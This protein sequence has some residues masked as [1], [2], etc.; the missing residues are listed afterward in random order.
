MGT[1][2][3]GCSPGSD[4]PLGAYARLRV[5]AVGSDESA[6]A[7]EVEAG[8]VVVADGFFSKT[9]QHVNASSPLPLPIPLASCYTGG[10]RSRGL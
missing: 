5:R 3:V 7:E 6:P 4:D 10:L 1:H 9:R 2:V 8:L